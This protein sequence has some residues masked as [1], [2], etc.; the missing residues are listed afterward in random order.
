MSPTLL[1]TA[2]LLTAE[3]FYALPQ[4]LDGSR[5]ELVRGRI[6][7]MPPPSTYH[8]VCCMEIGFR[9]RL[10]LREHPIGWL[11]SNDSGFITERDPDTVRG[12]D[13]SFWTR[14][15]LPQ[16]PATGYVALAPDL[17]VEVVSPSDVFARLERKLLH[18]LQHRIRLIWVLA[19][20]DRSISVY[21][22]GHEPTLP[23]TANT[24][25]GEDVLPGFQC[26]ISDLF[27]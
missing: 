1:P 10:Y 2:K 23:T 21:R 8:G 16:L 17:V 19:P 14:E 11:A 4:P 5:Q 24:L 18:Y 13:L 27:P 25:S 26:Q 22:P 12:P 7:A 15:R 20:E 6:E 3:E 9:L